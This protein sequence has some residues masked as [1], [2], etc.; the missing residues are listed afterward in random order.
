[1][2][3]KKLTICNFRS[4]YGKKEF[5]FGERL[6]LILGSNGDGK[7]TF[8][9][10]LNWVLTPVEAA[11]R[12]K[13]EEVKLESLI[14][15]KMLRNLSEGEK[16]NVYVS[17][18]I[19]YETG[20][21]SKTKIIE[22]GFIVEKK[23][24]K[25]VPSNAYHDAFDCKGGKKGN[26]EMMLRTVLESDGAF[27][28]VLKKYHLFK[29]EDKLNIFDD[30]GTLQNLI[31]LYSDVK[32]IVPFK[33]F[34]VFAEK[35]AE[36]AMGDN[37]RKA[38]AQAKALSQIEKDIVKLSKELDK[39]EVALSDA[40]KNYNDAESKLEG[41]KDDMASIKKINEHQEKI[42][43]CKKHI[44]LFLRKIDEE[45]GRMLLDNLWIL[46]GFAPILD[47][48]NRKMSSL[49]LSK[50]NIEK[51]Y[52]K[53]Q[54]EEL[55]KQKTQK[56]KT[57][58]EKIAWKMND[59]EKMKY[60][61]H[62]HRCAICGSEAIEG[63][64]T[65]DFIKQRIHDVIELLTPKPTDK[66]IELKKYFSGENIEELRKMGEKLAD[67]DSKMHIDIEG[68]PNA[69]KAK[70]DENQKWRNGIAERD[71]IIDKTNKKIVQLNAS[72]VSGVNLLEFANDLSTVNQWYDQKE[73]S[74]SER[75]RLSQITIPKKKEEL[76][77]KREEQ[78]KLM[79]AAGNDS[80]FDVFQFFQHFCSA[81]ESTE[82]SSTE[83]ILNK[84]S[85]DA[86]VFLDKLNV[87]DFHGII[88]IYM[89]RDKL[90]IDLQDR[91]GKVITNP[92]TS[93]LTTMHISILLAISELTKE[94]VSK[95]AEYPLIFDA[96]TSSFD[97]GKD[98]SFYSCIA[99]SIEKQCIIVTKSFLY[100]DD[101]SGEYVIDYK[102]LS[103]LNCKKFRIKKLSDNFD[104]LDIA[105]IDTQVIE[106]KED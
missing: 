74:G 44:T 11:K 48:Y 24:G 62:T 9:E 37:K 80:L 47:E 1:M 97:E 91:N 102:A 57:E 49:Y 75:D 67:A 50:Q 63:S 78:K 94:S 41:L 104:K 2:I 25:G 100:K 92:N 88:R 33:Q 15:A 96:P 8:F 85:K 84:L 6:N 77:K 34:A 98:K 18:E 72:S 17:I 4:Y 71:V 27:P 79:K 66:K 68:I 65:Y 29:G 106:I 95:K 35:K 16:G 83:N 61:L 60:M 99:E 19:S 54:E 3:I 36:M 53:K 52:E 14:S 43:E 87:D 26:K 23:A 69:I 103:E 7:T 13:E 59:V 45:Y 22:R 51:E 89:H 101:K 40:K 58:L 56:A 28:A 105:T 32:D 42:K 90:T 12:N 81:V 20:K 73:A 31:D 55:D 82:A 39:Y 21:F 93:L 76:Q 38:T 86:N 70:F 30:K 46:M 10:A 64:I 5:V